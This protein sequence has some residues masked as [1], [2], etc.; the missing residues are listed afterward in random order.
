MLIEERSGLVVLLDLTWNFA[1]METLINCQID[2]LLLKNIG[3]DSIFKILASLKK[4]TNSFI[5]HN[6]L[7]KPFEK[8]G[9]LPQISHV[10]IGR[11][12][13]NS[14]CAFPPSNSSPF[15]VWQLLKL[16][17]LILLWF[18]DKWYDCIVTSWFSQLE[19]LIPTLV[20]LLPN[21]V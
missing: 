8:N 3:M 9:F 6:V 15:L 7:H 11:R 1:V 13:L 17:S 5:F 18:I 10:Q 19:V 14:T 21:I 4:I 2:F 12:F 20:S 16:A